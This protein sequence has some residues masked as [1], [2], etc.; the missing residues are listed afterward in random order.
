VVELKYRVVESKRS[1]LG[2]WNYEPVEGGLVY[3][4]VIPAVPAVCARGTVTLA[5]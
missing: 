3:V 2:H 4:S 1:V 5:L